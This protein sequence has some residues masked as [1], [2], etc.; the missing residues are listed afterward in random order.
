[1]LIAM[2]AKSE[3][4]MAICSMVYAQ[5]TLAEESLAMSQQLGL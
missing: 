4:Q 2:K 3:D 5:E 1:M